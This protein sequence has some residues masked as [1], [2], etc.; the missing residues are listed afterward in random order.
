MVKL[1][2]LNNRPLVVNPDHIYAAEASPDT[3]LRLIGGERMLVRETLEEL[4]ELIIA[5]RRR[6]NE[7]TQSM[8]FGALAV[9]EMTQRQA[10]DAEGALNASSYREPAADP[11]YVGDG[12]VAADQAARSGRKEGDQ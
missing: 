4:I 8:P 1:T 5:F 11:S 3:T 10:S 6:V 12:A 2:R 9:A 7:T